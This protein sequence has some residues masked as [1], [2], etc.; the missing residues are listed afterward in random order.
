MPDANFFGV[1]AGLLNLAAFLPYVLAMYGWGIAWNRRPLQKIIPTQPNRATWFIWA[2]VGAVILPAYSSSGADETI[3]VP[4]ALTAGPLIVAL[5]SIRRGE[6]GWT[7]FDQACLSGACLSVFM[8]AITGSPV[9]GLLFG[10]AADGFGVAATVRHAYRHPEQENR[11]AWMLFL[12][13]DITN[14]FAVTDW[15][16]SAFPIWFLTI[17]MVGHTLPIVAVL[18]R[19]K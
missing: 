5:L 17:Y 8:W 1:V 14:L 13:G 2:F 10:L 6:G 15:S 18:Y 3:W 7:R 4:A 11:L 19:Q 9:V 16:W 12:I